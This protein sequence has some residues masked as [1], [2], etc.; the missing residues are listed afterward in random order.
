MAT[1][2]EL[3]AA[4]EAARKNYHETQR[5]L[6]RE[7]RE[8]FKGFK[9]LK[10]SSQ[11]TEDDAIKTEDKSTQ[12]ETP[13]TATKAGIETRNESTQM[14]ASALA[15]EV[16][17]IV[18]VSAQK[19]KALPD[20]PRIAATTSS[21]SRNIPMSDSES[22]PEPFV[23][24]DRSSS[25]PAPVAQSS[26][27]PDCGSPKS[28]LAAAISLTDRSSFSFAKIPKRNAANSPGSSSSHHDADNMPEISNSN[29]QE[30]PLWYKNLKVKSGMSRS[31]HG[32][33]TLIER[34][35]RFRQL[36]GN[37]ENQK[38]ASVR[39][40]AFNGLREDLHRLIFQDGLNDNILKEAR[41][42]DGDKGLPRIFDP[43]PPIRVKF[44]YDIQSDALELYNKFC[45][46][47]YGTDILRGI[48]LGRPDDK[49]NRGADKI[50]QNYEHRK[51]ADVVGE[52]GLICG[53]WW[54][55]QLTIVRDGGHGSTQG[56]K[57][58]CTQLLFGK[59]LTLLGIYGNAETGAYSVVMSHGYKDDRDEGNEV[60]YCG[61]DG[62][63]GKATERTKAMKRSSETGQ[64]VR[65]FR[66]YNMPK[67]SAYKPCEGFRYDGLYK[68]N[69]DA[70]L[71]N[72]EK[73]IWQFHLT[74][75]DNQIPIRYR[76]PEARP[77]E[78]ERGAFW[79]IKGLI[80]SR[81]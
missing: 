5:R 75:L 12:M 19:R 45:E 60:W 49:G 77:T 25:V 29:F 70:I 43:Q 10:K 48:D 23:G 18:S 15:T 66:S 80:K 59:H 67:S 26:V 11:D 74:R 34:L 58:L 31:Q 8:N 3:D 1:R 13:P 40:E 4:S 16:D 72:S 36:I 21:K 37:C 50:D 47:D 7:A 27:S 22:S 41:M 69:R 79:K 6:Y 28:S 30:P 63:D 62:S 2:E 32:R 54:P 78:E 42:L 9:P 76:G 46:R 33:R 64:S 24:Y 65:L 14:E 20:S 56:G 55:T 57:T 73:Q 38:S 53:Q 71:K 35:V 17:P 68:V 39:G 51:K 44:P 61:T 81:E 52:N